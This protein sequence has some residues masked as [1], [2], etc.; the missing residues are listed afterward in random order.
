M[1]K[2]INPK[3]ATLSDLIAIAEANGYA[4]GVQLVSRSKPQA[5]VVDKDAEIERLRT[6]L[7]KYANTVNWDFNGDSAEIF[8]LT[9]DGYD[10]AREALKECG[11]K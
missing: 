8:R 10:I 2:K 3:K 7:E 11:D 4:V 6:A 5:Q 1:T 9:P